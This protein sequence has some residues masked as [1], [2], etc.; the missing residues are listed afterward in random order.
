MGLRPSSSPVIRA[1]PLAAG[2]GGA[3]GSREACNREC[4]SCC[5]GES[6]TNHLLTPAWL[7]PR[8]GWANCD[9][10]ETAGPGLGHQF[11]TLHAPP[12]YRLADHKSL[13]MR[14]YY[15]GN[16]LFP[17]RTSSASPARL[18]ENLL[19]SPAPLFRGLARPPHVRSSRG[20]SRLRPPRQFGYLLTC[21]PTR[22]VP[23]PQHPNPRFGCTETPTFL[24]IY[25]LSTPRTPPPILAN[26]RPSRLPNALDSAVSALLALRERGC[27]VGQLEGEWRRP[28]A[29]QEATGPPSRRIRA[30]G[31]GGDAER[32]GFGIR[33]IGGG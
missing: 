8:R 25:C 12:A 2:E 32:R 16:V 1:R 11:F 5:W 24:S 17:R 3:G 4:C 18:L 20:H 33:P 10:E 15:P 7:R 30:G 27:S 19:L 28:M 13:C 31:G 21:P 26:K 23:G 9:L 22:Q 14:P 29:W 6:Q